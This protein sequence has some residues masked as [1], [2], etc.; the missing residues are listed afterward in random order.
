MQK[1][2]SSL[3]MQLVLRDTIDTTYRSTILKSPLF[4]LYRQLCIY[5]SKYLCKYLSTYAVSRL[6]ESDISKT[7]EACLEMAIA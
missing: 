5:V 2:I 4:S 6:A 3:G 7:L 1:T